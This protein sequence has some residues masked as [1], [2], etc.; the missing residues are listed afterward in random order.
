MTT[1]SHLIRRARHT[2]RALF[3]FNSFT[4]FFGASM[5]VQFVFVSVMTTRTSFPQRG[6]RISTSEPLSP[7]HNLYPHIGQDA[8]IFMIVLPNGEFSL[9]FLSLSFCRSFRKQTSL[10]LYIAAG[11]QER[12]RPVHR[13]HRNLRQQHLPPK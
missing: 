4:T 12:S 1:A 2:C 13:K 5:G 8:Y 10:I 9:R 7:L 11:E 6:Q 3:Y